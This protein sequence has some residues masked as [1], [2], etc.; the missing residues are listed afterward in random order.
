[1]YIKLSSLQ[2]GFEWAV[3]WNLFITLQWLL[4]CL[5]DFRGL[6]RVVSKS[7]KPWSFLTCF[8]KNSISKISESFRSE[9]NY[10]TN[11]ATRVHHTLLSTSPPSL[12]SQQQCNSQGKPILL[13]PYTQKNGKLCWKRHRCLLNKS[14][15]QASPG[16][17][18]LHGIN[19]RS[20]LLGSFKRHLQSR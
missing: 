18:M 16:T 13:M 7:W 4:S 11:C 15:I 20:P 6:F 19:Q 1:M 3:M 10:K 12:K 9:A 17:A 14:L 8:G 2:C 5:Q